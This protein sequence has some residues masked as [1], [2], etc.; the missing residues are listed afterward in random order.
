M[1]LTTSLHAFSQFLNNIDDFFSYSK[2]ENLV[3]S[4]RSMSVL[5]VYFLYLNVKRDHDSL[6]SII[7][8]VSLLKQHDER[9]CVSKVL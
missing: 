4:K 8:A 7:Y 6:T 9:T 3:K 2:I 1:A 5:I